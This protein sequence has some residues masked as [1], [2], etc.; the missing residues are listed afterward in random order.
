M[1]TAASRSASRPAAAARSTASGR[2]SVVFSAAT[3]SAVSTAP[4]P[5]ASSASRSAAAPP[6]LLEALRDDEGERVAPRAGAVRAEEQALARPEVVE[7][8]GGREER[9]ARVG[10]ADLV[11]QHPGLDLLRREAEPARRPQRE[12]RVRLV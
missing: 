6:P 12:G 1:P 5:T 2:T 8:G 4:L 3:T 10:V 9:R 11:R 7:R